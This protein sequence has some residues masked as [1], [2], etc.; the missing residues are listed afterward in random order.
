MTPTSFPLTGRETKFDIVICVITSLHLLGRSPL[1]RERSAVASMIQIVHSMSN[2]GCMT[3][4]YVSAR[5][6]A[7]NCDADA[8]D[9]PTVTLAENMDML[10]GQRVLIVRDLKRET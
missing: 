2:N 4:A 1:F 6:L 9:A 5:C 8:Q 10:T 3:V 7:E